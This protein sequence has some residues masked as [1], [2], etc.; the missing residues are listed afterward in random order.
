MGQKQRASSN[1][2]NPSRTK[3]QWLTP[4]LLSVE[5]KRAGPCGPFSGAVQPDNGFRLNEMGRTFIVDSLEQP[6]INQHGK[7][8]YHSN[9]LLR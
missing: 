5:S 8:V 6:M 9:N 3:H 2:V 1:N 7:Q 4:K